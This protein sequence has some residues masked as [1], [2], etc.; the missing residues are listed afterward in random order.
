MTSSRC[1]GDE[2]G[3]ALPGR[4]SS[5]RPPGRTAVARARGALGL[6]LALL[7]ALVPAC[8]SSSEAST[9]LESALQSPL[10]DEA[11]VLMLPRGRAEPALGLSCL[12][13][14]LRFH[15]YEPDEEARRRFGRARVERDGVTAEAVEDYLRGRGFE[16]HVV[17][18]SLEEDD[19]KG[20]PMLLAAGI[21]VLVQLELGSARFALVT[22][23]DPVQRWVLIADPAWG[24]AAI[25]QEDFET[26]WAGADHVALVAVPKDLLD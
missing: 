6:L 9:G 15:G 19:L 21:P 8:R 16:T 2:G 24:V 20:L 23:F 11:V 22:G 14:L 3:P 26:Y 12:E 4:A 10:S 25:E 1:Q 18:G 5:R 17:R 13:G 7:V